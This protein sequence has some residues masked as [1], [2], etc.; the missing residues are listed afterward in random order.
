MKLLSK[1]IILASTSPRRKE[2]LRSSGIKFKT[3]PSD[4]EEKITPGMSVEKLVQNLAY[5]KV[6]VVA[7][8]YP[9]H[10]VV[11][12]DTVVVFKDK[13]Y[14][15]PINKADALRTLK[16]F[17]G[18]RVKVVSGIALYFWQRNKRIFTDVDISFVHFKK[19]SD[20]DIKGYIKSGQ[21]MD[22]AGSFGIQGLGLFLVDKLEGNYSAIMGLPLLKVAGILKK[23][24]IRIL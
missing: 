8:K 9:R 5:G 23:F 12:A 1:I 20:S 13:I 7:K 3:V 6:A 16:K 22:K 21:P 17:S 24:N 18:K 4:F 19:L 11:G 15:K 10:I 14:G 2:V